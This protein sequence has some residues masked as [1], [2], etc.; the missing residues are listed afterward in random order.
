[1][2]LE[3]AIK[4][5]NELIEKNNELF[6]QFLEKFKAA[7][8]REPADI[9]QQEETAQVEDVTEPPAEVKEKIQKAETVEAKEEPA[10]DDAEENLTVEDIRAAMKDLVAAKGK[11]A[12]IKLLARWNAAS[13][14][15][16]KES[17][18]AGFI[19]DARNC[20]KGAAA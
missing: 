4:K 14:S 3:A 7:S 8:I 16:V 19:D 11:P 9:D 15:G 10:Q 20:M 6:E 18:Y 12:A 1:M 17:D 5:N 13:A 2:S